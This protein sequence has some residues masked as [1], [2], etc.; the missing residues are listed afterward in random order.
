MKFIRTIALATA[1]VAGALSPAFAFSRHAQM[2]G[3]DST[4]HSTGKCSGGGVQSQEALAL[5]QEKS[6]D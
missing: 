2:T 6:L 4:Y 3:Y 1:L 5:V